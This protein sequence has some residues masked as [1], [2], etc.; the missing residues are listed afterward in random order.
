[1]ISDRFEPVGAVIIPEGDVVAEG[2]NALLAPRFDGT[3]HAEMEALRAVPQKLWQAAGR[4]TIYSTL[5]P[6]LMCCAAILMHGIGRV[7]FGAHDNHGGAGAV[8]NHLP[9]Y[10]EGRLEGVQWEGPLMPEDCD[11]LL[12]RLFVMLEESG[13]GL[14]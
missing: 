4:M 1:M 10:F 7:V 11:S 6:C 13:R 8:L 9:P 2:S 5:E 14:V 12:E 3:R